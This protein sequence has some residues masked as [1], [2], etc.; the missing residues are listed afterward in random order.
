MS[1]T[2]H[3]HRARAPRD[4]WFF[5]LLLLAAGLLGNAVWMLVD[6]LRWYHELPAGVPDFGEFNP[7]FVRDIGCAFLTVGVALAWAAFSP[8]YRFPLVGMASLFLVAHAVLHV[9]DTGRGA[10]DH[11]HWW[12]DL[13]GVYAPAALTL[14][15]TFLLSRQQGEPHAHPTRREAA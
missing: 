1:Q 12:L 8:R 13:P 15:L 4:A 5:G 2:K 11:T 7:H 10:V 3:A 9:Y 14:W 6:P